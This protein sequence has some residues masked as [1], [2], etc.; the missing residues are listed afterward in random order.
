MKYINKSIT[1]V[2]CLVLSLMSSCD[3]LSVD[4]YFDDTLK[5]DTVFAYKLNLEK[6]LWGA[7]GELPDESKIFGND[8]TPGITAADDIFTLMN[9]S[10]FHGKALTLGEVTASDTKGL[11]VWGT[12]YKVIRK[13]NTLL[14][15]ID[16]CK[17]ITPLQKQELIGYIHFLRGYSYY[18]IL[19]NHG[20]AVLLGD[21][22]MNSNE[23][24]AYYD[25][26]RATYDETVEYICS[27]LETAAKYIPS[28]IPIVN[29]GRPTK[30]AAYAIIARVR[31][32]AAS[33]AFNG[34][35][36]AFR[37]FGNWT[38]RIDGV[39]YVS[40]EYNERKWALAAAAAKRV[41]EMD[42][43]NRYKLH[44][45]EKNHLNETTPELPAEVSADPFPNGAGDIDPF[46]SYSNMFNGA[47]FATQ[48]SEFI[49]ARPS[50]ELAEYTRQSFPILLDGYNAMCLTQK[51]VDAYKMR[52]GKT[53]KEAEEV[54]EYS[55][56]G[57][58]GPTQVFSGY[59]INR[60]IHNMYNNREMRFYACVGFSG[61]FWLGRSVT[62]SK[63]SSVTVE[64]H[65]GGNADKNS[66]PPDKEADRNYC[67]TGY[68]LRKYIHPDDNWYEGGS[69]VAKTFPIIRYA[70][71][72]L[73]YAEAVNHLTTSHTIT[74][75]SGEVYELSRNTEL[76][77]MVAAFNQV[78]YRAGL[79]GLRPQDYATEES[80]NEQIV[81]ERFVEFMAEGKRFYDLR[82][83]G[84][85][86]NEEN[87]PIE[88]M[89]IEG[90]KNEFCRR[91]VI[92]NK[93]YRNRVVDKKT[94][95][96]PLP[97][98]EVRKAPSLDQNP[99]W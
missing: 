4:K 17:D 21:E 68:V 22:V 37:Y 35:A 59:R 23:V 95:F 51:M 86:E 91:T 8:V 25:R 31:L 30:G 10:L 18:H 33:P 7:A 83:W 88:G 36:A 29:F 81:T 12:C 53:I 26:G 71:I 84:I 56:E 85:Y 79:P 65:I 61:C 28:D 66:T 96:L 41:M 49:W 64:Y 11:G 70:E 24:A 60:G 99:G 38:R 50:G 76:Q 58:S 93:D 27:E 54:G 6:Y 42:N 80:M 32:Q 5:Y 55:E 92:N 3:F 78:R 67:V 43:G 72:L 16:E 19:M 77:G 63:F 13:A 98:E 44:T 9:Q 74:M 1:V 46:K 57:F 94:V 40:Q 97:W 62:N 34:E 90:N 14:N 39:Q 52:D 82:R 69:R 47:T 73:S 15:R 20:P 48:N 89:N 2:A 87:K 75:E 45:V